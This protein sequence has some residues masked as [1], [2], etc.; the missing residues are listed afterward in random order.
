M[1][2][3]LL[4][5]PVALSVAY[6]PHQLMSCSF[7]QK[8]PNAKAGEFVLQSYRLVNYSSRKPPSSGRGD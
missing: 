5:G 4:G 7:V 3:R 8:Q 6:E 1:K 2:E